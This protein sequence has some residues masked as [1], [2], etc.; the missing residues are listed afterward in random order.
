M[1]ART[2]QSAPLQIDTLGP[3][4]QGRLGLTFC[5]GK[6]APHAQTGAWDRDLD[7]DLRALWDWGASTVVTL[8]ETHELELL[9]VPGFGGHVSRPGLQWWLLP[10]VDGGV[11]NHRLEQACNRAVEDLRCR[12]AP[13]EG[14]VIHCRGGLGR[15]GIVAVRLLVEFGEEPESALFRVR[16]QLV[17]RAQLRKRAM[18]QG[19]G[20]GVWALRTQAR[21]ISVDQV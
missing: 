18:R 6:H 20:W 11:P 17:V 13:G 4:G 12:L 21:S 7:T 10:I 8:M 5:P 19:S 14:I 16:H 15:T 3:V 9:R 1:H 2:T